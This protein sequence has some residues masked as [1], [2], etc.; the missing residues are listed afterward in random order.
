[1]KDFKVLTN[2]I[3]KLF[4]TLSMCR[5]SSYMYLYHWAWIWYRYLGCHKTIPGN[6]PLTWARIMLGLLNFYLLGKN[7]GS[8]RLQIGVVVQ[9]SAVTYRIWG[10]LPSLLCLCRA[11]K[12]MYSFHTHIWFQLHFGIKYSILLMYKYKNGQYKQVFQ[13]CPCTHTW[14]LDTCLPIPWDLT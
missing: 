1:M 8:T 6:P 12:T 9:C 7:L 2:A 10:K 5:N 13:T 11:I 4:S 3:D 14:V